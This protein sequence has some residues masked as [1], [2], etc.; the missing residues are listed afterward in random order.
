MSFNTMGV[1]LFYHLPT[2]DKLRVFS[3]EFTTI[4]TIKYY[5]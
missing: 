1:L 3:I 5:L 4:T 2:H